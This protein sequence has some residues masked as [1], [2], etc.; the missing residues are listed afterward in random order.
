M[1]LEL[2]FPP[3][4]QRWEGRVVEWVTEECPPHAVF[5]R[6]AHWEGDDDVLEAARNAGLPEADNLG[7]RILETVG[8]VGH[9]L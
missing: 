7:M 2:A 4:L 8:R 9:F 3:G 1:L 6:D 5:Y